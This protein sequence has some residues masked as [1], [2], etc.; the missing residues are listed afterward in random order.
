MPEIPE[1]W[2]TW[3]T[4]ILATIYILRGILIKF[5][6]DTLQE[7]IRNASAR[8]T[9]REEHLQ[10]IEKAQVDSRLQDLATER[11][12]ETQ[13]TEKLTSIISSQQNFI[14]NVMIL[15]IK[16]VAGDVHRLSQEM[17][18]LRQATMR[19]GDITAALFA[20]FR[21]K[22]PTHMIKISDEIAEMITELNGINKEKK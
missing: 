3:A 2:P 6:P 20:C 10:E 19:I 9:D 17:R 21:D 7:F 22:D 4:L 1:D 5:L 14:Q 11:L 12:Q 15:E 16:A 13:R 18:A 8:Q